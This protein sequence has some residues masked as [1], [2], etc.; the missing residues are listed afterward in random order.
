MCGSDVTSHAT[1][2]NCTVFL[3]L[4]LALG[5]GIRPVI[6]ISPNNFQYLI[7]TETDEKGTIEVVENAL[8]GETIQ[9]RVS[10]NKGY[11][12]KSII[13]RTDSGEE[14]EFNE[15]EIIKNE[16]GTISID[17]NKFTMPYENVTIEAKW[18]SDSIINPET[19]NKTITIIFIMTISL[20][21]VV[22]L[23]KKNES[24]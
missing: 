2:A 11:K 22:F 1:M 21:I 15:G 23:Y 18:Q 14:I 7:K 8:G 24:R 20:G 9:F 4:N 13:I 3:S 5:A 6:T 17:K 19:G 16:D 10:V 12:L